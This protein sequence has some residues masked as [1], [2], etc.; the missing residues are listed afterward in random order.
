M[1]SWNLGKLSY[2]KKQ[3][4]GPTENPF[5]CQICAIVWGKMVHQCCDWQVF[6]LYFWKVWRFSQPKAIT[7]SPFNALSG[8]W[9]F[10]RQKNCIQE[11]D[12][13]THPH[14][15]THTHTHP[16]NTHPPHTPPPTH[17]STHPTSLHPPT[18][19]QIRRGWLLR[20]EA[21]RIRAQAVLI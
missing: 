12:K 20:L 1:L 8:F 18:H 6:F 17:T 5:F 14:T 3:C 10:L 13:Y 9:N 2:R 21:G 16:H 7:D 4:S 19:T 15:H 11:G